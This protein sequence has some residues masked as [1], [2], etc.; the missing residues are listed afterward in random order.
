MGEKIYQKAL[1][2]RNPAMAGYYYIPAG[3][4]DVTVEP[5]TKDFKYISDNEIRDLIPRLK[6]DNW[7]KIT[8]DNTFRED[9]LKVINRLIDIVDKYASK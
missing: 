4:Y 2:Y 6:N 8:A 5:D 7:L 1:W 9:D 3:Y